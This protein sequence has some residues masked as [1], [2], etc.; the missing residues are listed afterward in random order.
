MSSSSVI[1]IQLRIQQQMEERARLELVRRATNLNAA[2]E[3]LQ[4]QMQDFNR[5]LGEMVGRVELPAFEYQNPELLGGPPGIIRYLEALSQYQQTLGGRFANLRS[6]AVTRAFQSFSEASGIRS[7]ADS[8]RAPSADI[9]SSAAFNARHRLTET[10]SERLTALVQL[11]CADDPKVVKRCK[12]WL[13]KARNERDDFCDVLAH[14]EQEICDSISQQWQVEAQRSRVDRLRIQLAGLDGAEVGRCHEALDAA[15]WE[16]RCGA[17]L[18]V[19]VRNA[20]LAARASASARARAEVYRIFLNALQARGHVVNVEQGTRVMVEGGR[21]VVQ[22]PNDRNWGREHMVELSEAS[23]NGAFE[24][25]VTRVDGQLVG[26]WLS[27]DVQRRF[28]AVEQ[29][30]CSDLNA[31]LQATHDVGIE[32]SIAPESFVVSKIQTHDHR[33]GGA[34]RPKTTP[35][36]AV[37]HMRAVNRDESK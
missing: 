7:S 30:W 28:A 36:D 33:T 9:R 6:L 32:V 15:H 3:R 35:A 13:I 37:R 34:G 8:L 22:K 23:D 27:T 18:E 25:H 12:E 10:E 16:G 4:V 21:L 24:A 14:V 5:Q 19:M 29:E 1:N 31:A 20:V 26:A 2:A 11:H 17:E